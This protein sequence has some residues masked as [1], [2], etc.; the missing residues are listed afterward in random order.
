MYF[1]FF[2]NRASS[3]N[4]MVQKVEAA[5]GSGI[6]RLVAT[7]PAASSAGDHTN[8]Q[9]PEEL[10][11]GEAQ[12]DQHGVAHSILKEAIQLW[13][14]TLYIQ[15][16]WLIKSSGALRAAVFTAG[17]RHCV[18]ISGKPGSV[19]PAGVIVNTTALQLPLKEVHS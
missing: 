12:N 17:Q 10:D 13:L 11:N 3:A 14:T 8:A 9:H 6:K 4:L 5:A 7:P 15:Q 19:G 18:V 2:L 16:V 1:F